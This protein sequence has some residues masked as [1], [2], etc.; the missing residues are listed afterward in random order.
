[1]NAVDG[2]S[3]ATRH[4]ARKIAI[5]FKEQRRPWFRELLVRVGVA[6]PDGLAFQLALLVDGAVAGAL[7]RLATR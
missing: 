5:A 3:A 4:A 6:Y 2:G 7:V 1:M